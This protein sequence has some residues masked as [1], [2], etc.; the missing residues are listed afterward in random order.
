MTSLLIHFFIWLRNKL[1]EQNTIEWLHSRT[2]RELRDMGI[3]RYDIDAV[4]KG[5]ND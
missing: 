3:T 1:D 2:D 5:N 4:V